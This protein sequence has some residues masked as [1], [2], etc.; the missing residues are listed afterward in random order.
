VIFERLREADWTA[1]LLTTVRP[2]V[3]A[4]SER[5]RARPSH[6]AALAA[7]QHPLVRSGTARIS[8]EMARNGVLRSTLYAS[9][10]PLGIH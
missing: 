1:E 6:H 2:A 10:E 8:A 3:L 9:H 7:H 4:Y 5:L